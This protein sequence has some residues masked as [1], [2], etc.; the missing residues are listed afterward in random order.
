[1]HDLSPMHDLS[2]EALCDSWIESAFYQHVCG[3]EVATQCLGSA[4]DGNGKLEVAF[5]HEPMLA[6]HVDLGILLRSSPSRLA[7]RQ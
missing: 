2:D 5:A 1:M 6:R 4:A 7:A 3:E